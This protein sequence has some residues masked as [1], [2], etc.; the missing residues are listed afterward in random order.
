MIDVPTINV[1]R[2]KITLSCLLFRFQCTTQV[3]R[4]NF[5]ASEQGLTLMLI[6]MI[7]EMGN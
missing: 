4:T 1:R 6:D 7:R 2:A 5:Q 3:S